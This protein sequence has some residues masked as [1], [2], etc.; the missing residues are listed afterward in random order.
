ML[1]KTEMLSFLAKLVGAFYHVINVQEGM[2]EIAFQQKLEI[3]IKEAVLNP[4]VTVTC[5]LDE[6]NATSHVWAA[7][8]MLC[9]KNQ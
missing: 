5:V 7:R 2:D 1:G 8:D 4:T 9:D 6:T 3:V